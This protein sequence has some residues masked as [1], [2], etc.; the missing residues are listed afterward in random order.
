MNNSRRTDKTR[1]MTGLAILSA[2][3]VVLQIL[4]NFVKFGPA[5]I[6]LSLAPIIIGAAIYG[7]G[8]GAI[9]GFVFSAVV[10]IT[11]ILGWDGGFIM[12]LM[13]I[14]PVGSLLQG[15]SQEKRACCGYLRRHSVPRCKHR[16]IRHRYAR[17]LCRHIHRHGRRSGPCELYYLRTGGTEL[18]CRA[19]RQHGAK[20]RNIADNQSRKENEVER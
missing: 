1:R 6:T 20:L 16:I 13:G 14:S 10:V 9:L 5:S 19:G 4:S 12:M 7:T 17:V 3:V 15:D 2:I 18:P 11:G 8:A